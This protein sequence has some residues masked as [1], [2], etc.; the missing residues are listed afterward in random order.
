MRF[1]SALST[2]I[3]G[4]LRDLV[5][6]EGIGAHIKPLTTSWYQFPD[7]RHDGWRQGLVP[8][9]AYHEAHLLR[10]DIL[11]GD[12]EVAFILAVLGVKDDDEFASP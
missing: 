6:D 9:V 12:D 4:R 1:G 11:G 7:R 10:R 8:G 5:R 2:T 3:W